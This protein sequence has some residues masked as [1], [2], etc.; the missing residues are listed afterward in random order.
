MN[1][2]ALAA[3]YLQYIQNQSPCLGVRGYLPPL[4]VDDIFEIK[5]PLIAI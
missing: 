4:L 1:E 3:L 5:T 2:L